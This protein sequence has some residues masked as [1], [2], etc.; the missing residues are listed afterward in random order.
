MLRRI[1]TEKRISGR[2]SLAISLLA[3]VFL[4]GWGARP[5]HATPSTTYWTPDVMDIQ[6][7]NVWHI[8]IDNYYT[9]AQPKNKEGAFPT[10][11]GLTVGVLPF[12]KVNMEVGIDLLE[13]MDG[14]CGGALNNGTTIADCHTLGD[15]L[16]FNAKI[17][18]PEGTFFSWQPGVDI[19]VF[20]VGFK[21]QVTNMDIVDLIIGKTIPVLGRIH[22]AGYWANAGSALM[23]EGGDLA[24]PAKNYGLM[25]AFDHGF[26][27]VKDAAGNEYSKWVFAAD[28]ASGRNFLGGGGFGMYYYFTKDI[29]LLTGPVWFEDRTINGA[30]KWTTQLDINF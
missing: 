10:D 25:G 5:A 30:W 6:G 7:Y 1:N 3:I 8:G 2:T 26:M 27:N 11:V 21:P 18:V 9:I 14:I 16:L 15:A 19:G 4:L 12:T 29:S 13:P 22:V 28:W 17:G 20:D 24:N 23:H